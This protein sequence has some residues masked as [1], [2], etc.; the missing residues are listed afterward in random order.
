MGRYP[1]A[2]ECKE[3]KKQIKQLKADI[4]KMN[5]KCVKIRRGFIAKKKE[6][7]E[8]IDLAIF[9]LPECPDRAKSVLEPALK[10]EGG[11]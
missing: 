2:K 4:F 7:I 5:D 1:Y 9:Y 6:L 11:E 8:Q 10:Q 3:L